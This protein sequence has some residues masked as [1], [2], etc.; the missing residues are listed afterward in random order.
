MDRFWYWRYDDDYVGCD[1]ERNIAYGYNGDMNDEF[2]STRPEHM[3]Q[4]LRLKVWF[5]CD[6]RM[7]RWIDNDHMEQRMKRE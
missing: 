6:E 3:V 4:I 7:Q 2:S 5:F 1:V